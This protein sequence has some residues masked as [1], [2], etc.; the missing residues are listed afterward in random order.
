[1]HQKFDQ[2]T[3]EYLAIQYEKLKELSENEAKLSRD[4]MNVMKRAFK[5]YDKDGNGVLSPNEIWFFLESH[6]KEQGISQKPTK[7][8]IED[9]F[10]ELDED[11]SG[12]I[13]FDEFKNFLI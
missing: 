5:T 10:D 12:E 7:K 13:G 3:I 1:M 9:F 4:K 8:D 11:H 6:F 2:Y